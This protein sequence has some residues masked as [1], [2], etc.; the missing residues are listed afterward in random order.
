[1]CIRD[2]VQAIWT[3]FS[4]SS[5][6]SFFNFDF[7]FLSLQF[8]LFEFFSPSF[9]FHI[10]ILRYSDLDEFRG[11][12]KMG[13]YNWK[14]NKIVLFFFAYSLANANQP[15]H[16]FDWSRQTCPL[17]FSSHFTCQRSIVIYPISPMSGEEKNSFGHIE[18]ALHKINAHSFLTRADERS[19]F[20][21]HHWCG[22]EQNLTISFCS[23]KHDQ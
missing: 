7:L 23:E 5:S 20:L 9:Y 18:S 13:Q 22:R 16:S 15:F 10:K 6:S 11:R 17:L 8:N 1:M 2:S 3:N 19:R 12:D 14:T 4:S 21:T